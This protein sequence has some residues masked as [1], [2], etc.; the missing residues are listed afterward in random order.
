MAE[1]NPRPPAM[2]DAWSIAT[3]QRHGRVMCISGRMT[4]I[5]RQSDEGRSETVAAIA[6]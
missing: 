5:Q 6:E 1:V 2:A 3:L 4:V